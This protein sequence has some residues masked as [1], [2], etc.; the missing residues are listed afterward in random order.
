METDT[1]AAHQYNQTHHYKDP[2]LLITTFTSY[3]RVRQN[4]I[5]ISIAAQW[6]AGETQSDGDSDIRRSEGASFIAGGGLWTDSS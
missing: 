6:E 2:S 3:Y 1:V 4:N 5:P